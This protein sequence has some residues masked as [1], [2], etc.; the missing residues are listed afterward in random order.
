MLLL[1]RENIS[2]DEL[3]NSLLEHFDKNNTIDKDLF[4]ELMSRNL[5]NE[6]IEHFPK[7]IL[8]SSNGNIY[9]MVPGHN[10]N[11]KTE[12][13]LKQADFV[14]SLFNRDNNEN[15]IKKNT[16]DIKDQVVRF[17]SEI[18]EKVKGIEKGSD[19]QKNISATLELLK[20]KIENFKN[21]D[22]LKNFLKTYSQFH[23]YSLNNTLLIHFQTNGKATRVAGYKTWEKLGRHVKKGEKGIKI[24]APSY[25]YKEVP[26]KDKQGNI[27]LDENGNTITEKV[28][29][30]YFR[31]VTVFD[32]SQTEG[33]ELPVLDLSIKEDISE[34]D[35]PLLNY[36]HKNNINVTYKT[37]ADDLLLFQG[38]KGYSS[39]G[40]V[41]INADIPISD[42]T[43]VLIHELAHEK[44]HHNLP[45]GVVYTQEQEEMEADAVSFVVLNRYGIDSKSE[46]YLALYH[47][48]YDIMESLDRITKVSSDII[49][50]IDTYL[51]LQVQRD[52]V[53]DKLN[54]YNQLEDQLDKVNSALVNLSP[55][56]KNYD[57]LMQQ[58]NDIIE[59]LGKL[60]KAEINKEKK[61]IDNKL[62][63]YN[64]FENY[65]E[66]KLNK[67]KEE[68]NFE[69][70]IR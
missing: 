63:K 17:N 44:L 9:H 28:K 47:K 53:I 33:R 21:S 58:K 20:E 14:E 7:H 38:A 13:R 11:T 32:I 35:K 49:K 18:D 55:G 54:L 52:N 31:M 43:S 29:V 67:N 61:E 56:D 27:M 12:D 1:S 60:D 22:E 2:N 39:G 10:E 15:N 59:Q 62:K 48:D 69:E 8:I 16:I 45:E 40:K 37:P 25:Y 6:F 50:E 57:D 3:I 70:A 64:K 24:F 34:L 41:V 68:I 51:E 4:K 30:D 66:N 46:K 65:R 42:Q 23:N 5:Y 19:N 36:A 26:V